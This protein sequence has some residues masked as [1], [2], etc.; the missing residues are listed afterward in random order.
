MSE[1]LIGQ[2][3]EL[4]LDK[5]TGKVSVLGKQDRI[6][7]VFPESHK[8]TLRRRFASIVSLRGTYIDNGK[9]LDVETVLGTAA[10]KGDF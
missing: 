2:L 6:D 1:I 7:I 4:D 8:G 10:H 9:L 5:F 3:T